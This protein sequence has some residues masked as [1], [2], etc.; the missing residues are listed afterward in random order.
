MADTTLVDVEIERSV[1]F[2]D[3]TIEEST[4]RDSVV[5]EGAELAEVN[6]DRAM[7]GAYTRMPR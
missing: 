3:V 7:I 6:L 5:D 1:V 4:V 2:P